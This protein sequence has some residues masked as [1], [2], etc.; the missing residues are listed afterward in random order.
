MNQNPM[1]TM[2]VKKLML[3]TSVPIMFS[4]VLQAVYNIVDSAFVSNMDGVGEQALNAL[5]LA[6][7][8]Q[9]LLIAVAVGTGVGSN[10]LLS[11]TLGQGDRKKALC[12]A[13]NT[14]FLGILISVV[15]MIFGF[16]GVEAFISSQTTNEVILTM[17][18]DYLTICCVGCSG[19]VFFVMFEKL[20]Q[21]T[22]RALQST[23]AQI[24]GA[25]INIILDPILIYGL[26]GFEAYGVKGAAYATV[27]GQFGAMA[28]ALTFHLKLNKELHFARKD[29]KPVGP[30]M[31]EIYLI[32]FPAII[33]QAL[34]SFMAYGLN[35]IFVMAGESVVTVY[36]LYYKVQ[37]F[38]MMAVFGLRDGATPIM[39]FAYGMGKKDRLN[40][41]IKLFLTYSTVIMV[42]GTILF[43]VFAGVITSL[44]GFSGE[45]HTMC[46]IAL[47]ITALSFFFAGSNIS[48]QGALQALDSG[49]GSLIISLGR[50]II[51][52]L[53][54]A[55]LF[56]RL[57][58]GDASYIWTVWLTFLI[59]EGITFVISVFLLKGVHRNRVTTLS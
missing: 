40:H 53:P 9:M 13:G 17:G 41:A 22:G 15:F 5:T 12:V 31:R 18:V 44:F 46:V 58:M 48:I 28:V 23:I 16:V 34:S 8:I 21:S 42:V 10:V 47:R 29:L 54:V 32:G 39:A 19:I 11:R 45:V 24:T 14:V 55:Y 20:L 30:I 57:A 38:V 35:L 26:L 3:S 43:E 52:I 4:M 36:G 7:P 6:Y 49:L 51:F 1:A 56:T 2:P 25:V 50:Q 59:G 33:A 27:I 37:Q